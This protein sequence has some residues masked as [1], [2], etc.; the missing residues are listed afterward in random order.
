MKWTKNGVTY[1]L[2]YSNVGLLL[3]GELA[4]ICAFEETKIGMQMS[5]TLKISL[6]TSQMEEWDPPIRFSFSHDRVGPRFFAAMRTFVS[7]VL[8]ERFLV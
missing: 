4:E 3:N 7:T 5:H 8:N 1:T 2:V 6:M